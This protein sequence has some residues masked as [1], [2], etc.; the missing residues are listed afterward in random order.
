MLFLSPPPSHVAVN[1]IDGS[2][3]KRICV[4]SCESSGTPLGKI[5]QSVTVFPAGNVMPPVAVKRT[6]PAVSVTPVRSS[7]SFP[8]SS[9]ATGPAT[10]TPV[11]VVSVTPLPMFSPPRPDIVL[12]AAEP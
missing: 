8:L 6:S 11:G 3:V 2:G 7:A 10:V 12:S 1:T 4:P 9:N 5:T